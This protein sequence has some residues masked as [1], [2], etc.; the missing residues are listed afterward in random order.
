MGDKISMRDNVA[1]AVG[2]GAAVVARDIT[3]FRGRVESSPNIEADLKQILLEA[4]EKIERASLSD[5]DKEDA[6]ENLTKLTVELDKPVRDSG[7]IKRYWNRVKDVAPPVAA[8]LSSAASIA[9]IIEAVH[10]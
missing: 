2:R 9:K 5:P 6:T 7:L 3:I 8:L 4:R 10:K 1:G